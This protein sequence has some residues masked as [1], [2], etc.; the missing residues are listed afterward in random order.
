V[1]LGVNLEHPRAIDIDG[2]ARRTF[3]KEEAATLARLPRHLRERAFF[4]TW[5]RKESYCKALGTGLK[6]GLATFTVSVDPDRPPYVLEHAAGGL[7][8][9]TLAD[10]DVPGFAAALTARAPVGT[11]ELNE[12]AYSPTRMRRC[13]STATRNES[14]PNDGRHLAAR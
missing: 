12:L 10:L 14:A 1:E 4:A 5:A 3:S 9:W 8:D 2:I 6:T 7:N 13:A 11:I